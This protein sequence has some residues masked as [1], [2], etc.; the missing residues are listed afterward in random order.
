M[1]ACAEDTADSPT[2]TTQAEPVTTVDQGAAT[3]AAEPAE[4]V[5]ITWWHAHGEGIVDLAAMAKEMFEAEHPNVTVEIV[6]VPNDIYLERI[7]TAAAAGTLPD[8]IYAN[9]QIAQAMITQGVVNQVDSEVFADDL[10]YFA[11]GFMDGLSGP[12]GNLYFIPHLGGGNIFYLR[13]DL[14]QFEP[15]PET[16][17]EWVAWGKANVE[18]DDD[19]N[20]TREGLAWRIDFPGDN[21]PT[22]QFRG[23]LLGQGADLLNEDGSAS[24][25]NN[26]AGL[27]ALQFMHDT[28]W[29]HNIS[30]PLSR[31]PLPPEGVWPIVAGAM[32]ADYAGPW[33]IGPFIRVAEAY[34]DFKSKW[35]AQ[36][37]LPHPDDGQRVVMIGA[38]G[39]G[40][41]SSSE[42]PGLAAAFADV[43]TGRDMAIEFVQ[44]YNHPVA[45]SD[46]MTS[47]E[48]AAWIEEKM[49]GAGNWLSLWDGSLGSDV[50]TVSEPVHPQNPAIFRVI[51]DNISGMLEDENADLQAVLDNMEAEV[52][53]VIAAG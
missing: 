4:P 18:Y 31:K 45:R 24:A 50:I 30:A 2:T 35:D 32:A 8:V 9:P 38:D 7:L 6:G 41:T 53:D 11:Q 27:A 46:A 12:D 16:W 48:L 43:L 26:E 51:L 19:G 17:D 3:T 14:P 40:V 21:W 28:V 5:T 23:L 47:P 1:A 20:I 42:N 22:Y 13:T 49:P 44:A 34:P 52:N 39:W 37:I 10:E 25:F 33:A 36:Y 29:V 15:I